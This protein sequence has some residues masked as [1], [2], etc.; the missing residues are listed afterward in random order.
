MLHIADEPTW[1][2]ARASGVYSH[3]SG[4][5]HGC[6]SSQLA[7][8]V[9]AHFPSQEGFV[10]LSVDESQATG[11]VRSVTYRQGIQS[12]SFPHLHGSFPVSAVLRV[13]PL[14]EALAELE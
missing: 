5:I 11:E 6:S 3:P 2:R 8:V 7:M 12:E 4:V 10:V 13:C 1:E 14:Q 9:E